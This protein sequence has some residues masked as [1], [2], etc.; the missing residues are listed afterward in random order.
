M[1]KKK[2]LFELRILGEVNGDE[3]ACAYLIKDFFVLLSSKPDLTFVTEATTIVSGVATDPPP[4]PAR[5]STQ[6]PAEPKP[7]PE[8]KPFALRLRAPGWTPKRHKEAVDA[9]KV[10]AGDTSPKISKNM[11][12]HRSVA[13]RLLRGTRLGKKA[14]DDIISA[15]KKKSAPADIINK[16]QI[17]LE[18]TK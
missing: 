7:K 4:P 1:A 10:I 16:F 9:L 12:I 11:G 15:L 17:M 3:A 2:T 18:P 14:V 5:T 13:V 6:P 8:P